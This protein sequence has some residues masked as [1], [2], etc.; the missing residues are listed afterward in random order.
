LLL[1][2]ALDELPRWPPPDMLEEPPRWPELEA[3]LPP[4]DLL[5]AEP[6]FDPCPDMEPWLPCM[7]PPDIP[8]PPPCIEP[9]PMDPEPWPWPDEP[10]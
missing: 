6:W 5:L 1:L 2:D 9:I 4:C 8:C 3:E 10:E 7:E